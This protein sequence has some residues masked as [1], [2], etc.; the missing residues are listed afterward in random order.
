MWRDR[1]ELPLQAIQGRKAHGPLLDQP[2]L[3]L[4]AFPRHL[5][6]LIQEVLELYH[7]HS[8]SKS[9]RG[10]FSLGDGSILYLGLSPI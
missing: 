10:V 4:R 7:L 5:P 3:R 8:S 9:S 1:K 6:T 2:M